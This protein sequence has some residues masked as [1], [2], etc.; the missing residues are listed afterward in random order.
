MIL[1]EIDIV[2]K[3][4]S[5]KISLIHREALEHL[6]KMS[7]LAPAGLLVEIGVYRG[8]SLVALT[9]ARGK[10][11]RSI[12]VDDWSYPDPPDLYGKTMDV[13]KYHNIE[14]L[15]ELMSMTSEEAAK[16]I[17]G[18]LA[19]VHIDA[20][21][22]YPFVKQDIELWTPKLM[23]GGIAAFHD[24]GRSRWPGVKQAIDEW[25]A[26]EPWK[27]LGEVLTTAGWQKP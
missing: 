18:P 1:A 7:R 8:S 22:T 6:C 27:F 24:Y 23:S 19:F 12:G 20:D 25:Q 21:H 11:G 9:L 4:F 5:G 14:H 13:I 15:V 10:M 2:N 26:R 16:I 3:V 17:D